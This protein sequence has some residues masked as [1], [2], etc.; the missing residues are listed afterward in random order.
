MILFLFGIPVG[1]VVGA[2]AAFIGMAIADDYRKR[3]TKSPH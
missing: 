3:R 1:I 2:I